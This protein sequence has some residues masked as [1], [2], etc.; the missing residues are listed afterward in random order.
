MSVAH[1]PVLYINSKIYP[2]TCSLHSQM[3]ATTVVYHSGPTSDMSCV[4]QPH[5]VL[6]R[7][8]YSCDVFLQCVLNH[9]HNVTGF[10]I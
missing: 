10:N 9:R 7:K 3:S 2:A 6:D 1:L 4:M 8:G 5:G